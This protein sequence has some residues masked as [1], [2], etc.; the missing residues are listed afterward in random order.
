MLIHLKRNS[1][2]HPPCM[3]NRWAGGSLIQKP[4]DP[5]A[6]SWQ[7]QRGEPRCNLQLQFTASFMYLTNDLTK[8]NRDKNGNQVAKEFKTEQF[9]AHET[10]QVFKANHDELELKN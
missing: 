7:R 1:E 10:V 6:F 5:F 2:K 3:V 9:I 4:I 8:H